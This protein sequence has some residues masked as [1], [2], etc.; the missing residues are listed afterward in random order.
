MLSSASTDAVLR[1]LPITVK[2]SVRSLHNRATLRRLTILVGWVW[3]SFWMGAR[4]LMTVHDHNRKAGDSD[5]LLPALIPR[6]GM[7]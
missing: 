1:R 2:T 7:A 6:A 3:K 4:K 5:R